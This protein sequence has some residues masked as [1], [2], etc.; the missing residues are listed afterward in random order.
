MDCLLAGTIVPTDSMIGLLYKWVSWVG[1]CLTHLS[2]WLKYPCNRMCFSVRAYF[3]QGT[4]P[5]HVG[6]FLFW[7]CHRTFHLYWLS[8]NWNCLL[9]PLQD[10]DGLVSEAVLNEFIS[11]IQPLHCQL[12]NELLEYRSMSSHGQCLTD[13][14]IQQYQIKMLEFSAIMQLLS[15]KITTVNDHYLV[16]LHFQQICIEHVLSAKALFTALEWKVCVCVC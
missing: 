3:T 10:L 5:I 4:L 12:C 16:I 13:F 11:C 9:S 2:Y 15:R 6:L 14:T 7:I 1:T 8:H